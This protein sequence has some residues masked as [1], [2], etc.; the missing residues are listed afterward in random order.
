MQSEFFPPD[1]PAVILQK[2]SK[3]VDGRIHPGGNL[4]PISLSEVPEGSNYGIVLDGRYVLH[5]TDNMDLAPPWDEDLPAT[6]TQR[7][8]KGIHRLYALPN[9]FDATLYKN[10]KLYNQRGEMYGDLKVHGYFVGPGSTVIPKGEPSK[11]HTYTVMESGHIPPYSGKLTLRR[12]SDPRVISASD[13]VPNGAHADFLFK[14]L[15]TARG[16]AGLSES[17]MMQLLTKGPLHVLQDVNDAD[18][19][20]TSTLEGIVQSVGSRYDPEYSLADDTD[21][22]RLISIN[23]G[24]SD[25]WLP[26]QPWLITNFIPEN[27]LSLVYGRG[28]IGKSSLASFFVYKALK[29]G[30]KVVFF[31]SEEEPELFAARMLLSGEVTDEMM[32]RLEYIPKTVELPK[33]ASSLAQFVE[34]N[35]VQMVYFDSMMSHFPN[36]QI[37]NEAT[38]ARATLA[39]LVDLAKS[40]GVTI[41]GTF[42]EGKNGNFLGSEEMRNVGRSLLHA[43]LGKNQRMQLRVDKSNYFMP[44]YALECDAYRTCLRSRSGKKWMITDEDGNLF[45]REV[46][47]IRSL[48]KVSDEETFEVEPDESSLE[49]RAFALE[50]P[51]LGEQKLADKLG[52]TRHRVRVA[53]GK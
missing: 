1:T 46:Y 51:S 30:R 47:G 41:I 44:D 40:K 31:A 15:C 25:L 5:D 39:P 20:T 24:Q 9:G 45:E 21:D 3:I 52:I 17:A 28:G 50:N 11:Y 12:S 22:G 18:P 48:E 16:V 10:E 2:N 26:P 49:I 43:T 35:E 19:F 32:N 36:G 34:E 4:S 29:K 53:L 38:R 42:H 14:L 23:L 33:G 37:G 7:T 8:Y 27:Q 6:F 13:G